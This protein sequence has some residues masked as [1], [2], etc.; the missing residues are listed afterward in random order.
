MNKL[1]FAEGTKL[2]R[3]SRAG[4]IAFALVF[5]S[6][7]TLSPGLWAGAFT[8]AGEGN[9]VDVITHPKDYFGSGGVLNVGVCIDPASDFQNELEIPVRNNI[10][11]WNDLQPVAS[12]LDPNAVS[13]LDAESVLLHEVGHCIGLAHVNAA[14]ESGLPENDYTKATD[15]AN[16]G[17]DVNPGPDGIPGTFDDV[18]GDDENLHWF[19]P[20]NDPFQLPIHTPV[21]TS[22]YRRDVSELPPGD[23]FAQNASREMAAYYGLPAA[24]AVMQQ[25]T[26][27]SETQRELISDG[28]STIMLAASGLDETAGTADDYQLNLTYE[29]VATGSQCDITITVTNTS[30]FA[31]CQSGGSFINGHVRITSASVV[32]GNSYDWHFNTELRD[33]GGNQPPVAGADS[34]T[35]DEDSS[36]NI[37]VLGNDSDPDGDPLDVTGVSNPPNGTA[38][39]NGDDTINY[40]PDANFNGSDSFSY[41]LSDGN[42]GT[43]TGSVSVTV[44]P[45]NDAPVAANDTGITTAQD[46]PVDIFVLDNDSDVDGDALNVT[47]VSNGAIGTV[48]NNNGF[49]TYT[50][51]AGASGADSF[52]YTVSDGTDSDTANV[53]VS[54]LAANLLPTA[55]FTGSC[56]GQTCSFDASGSSDPDGSIV[57]YSWDFGDGA[58][59]SGVTPGHS[60]ASAG[61][62]TVTLTVTDDRSGSDVYS[63]DVTAT[64]DPV[65]PDYAVADFNTAQ[66]S[67]S[68]NYQATWAAGG[69]VQAI[70]ETHSGG[71]PSR[72]SDSLEHIW[73]FNLSDGNTTFNVFALGDFPGG[74]L[75]TAFQFEWSTSSN[76]GWNTMVS[77]P[78]AANTFDLPAGVSGTVY[79]RVTDNDSTQ[80]NTVL[81]TVSVDHMYFDG[82]TPPTEAP[83]A[84]SNPSPANGAT[85][86]PV[87]TTLSWM[88]G[89]GTDT[90]D[91]YFGTST[92][93]LSLVS[94]D[95]AGTSYSPGEL[96]TNTTYSWRIDETN[97]IGTTV[98]AVWSFTTS[99]NAGPTQL[100]VGSMVLS[101]VNAGKGNKNG[102][103]VVT[104]VD[105]LGNPVGGATVF[106][107]FSGSFNEPVSGVTSGGGT[108]TFTSSTTVKGGASFTFCV[109]NITGP[110]TYNAGQVCQ[111]F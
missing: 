84:A 106:G 27:Y 101:T 26:Y 85:G 86:V 29:G 66:G 63:D 69:A 107:S 79:V 87:N 109:D 32:L 103:A 78:G 46:T 73:Q 92:G 68:G 14:S 91:V 40:A 4:R 58:S 48:I 97:V 24:E 76:G 18:R 15:G 89:A 59:G 72:R 42:G 108:V 70:E 33:S 94:N 93:G 17:F 45:V 37:A 9:G 71:K 77:V 23:S 1:N 6:S 57:D 38:S 67:L 8:F 90:H 55:F 51:N 49:V 43:D 44:N 39:V 95:Q 36:V 19:N 34:G 83:A 41:T 75:D 54:V 28:A 10:A 25:L 65:D 3:F 22:Q 52:G 102:R 111:S 2:S 20:N 64:A 110:L 11:V 61:T 81:S 80:G 100:Q 105:D 50:P 7:M 13:G 56:D 16:N 30:S 5:L 47:A 88:A 62:Y 35:V 74:D 53:S 104:V 99:S 21:D 96:D 60:Y 12:N 82:A 31:Y 98:G